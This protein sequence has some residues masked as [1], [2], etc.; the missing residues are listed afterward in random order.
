MDE[1]TEATKYSSKKLKQN[2]KSR[3]QPL[4]FE[5]REQK[6]IIKEKRPFMRYDQLINY[7]CEKKKKKCKQF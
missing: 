2:F 4:R 1:T 5:N 3:K 6:E 7:N